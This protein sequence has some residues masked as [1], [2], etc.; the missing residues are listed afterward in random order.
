MVNP[1]LLTHFTEVL[2]LVVRLIAAFDRTR[3]INWVRAIR[4]GVIRVVFATRLTVVFVMILTTARSAT[5]NS[6][7][8]VAVNSAMW[9]KAKPA[10]F[11]IINF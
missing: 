6:S 5:T 8:F 4:L 3:L 7:D 11:A 10:W 1:I 2:L 9:L